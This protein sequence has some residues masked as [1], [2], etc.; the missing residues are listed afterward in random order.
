MRTHRSHST[1]IDVILQFWR[2]I[3][4][5]KCRTVTNRL[6]LLEHF[7]CPGI[8]KVSTRTIDAICQL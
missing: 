8:L 3:E 6:G 1:G 7:I 4:F 5:G 2:D